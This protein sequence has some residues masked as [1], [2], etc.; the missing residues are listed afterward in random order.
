MPSSTLWQGYNVICKIKC[1]EAGKKNNNNETLM[2]Y[3]SILVD[4][5]EKNTGKNVQII[6]NIRNIGGFKNIGKF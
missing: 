4:F 1:T 3:I 5:L 2:F 6:E